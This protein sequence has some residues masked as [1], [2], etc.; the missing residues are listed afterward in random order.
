MRGLIVDLRGNGGGS[1]V[2]VADL[3]GAFVHHAT[4]SYDCTVTGQCRPNEVDNSVPM[5]RLPLVVLTDRGCVSAC[6]AFSAGVKDLGLGELA[7]TRTGGL[8]SG[9]AAAYPLDDGSLL[10]LPPPLTSSGP[11]DEMVDGIGV[12]PDYYLPMTAYDLSTGHDPD[13][14]KAL[15]LLGNSTGGSSV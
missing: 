7:G 15:Q 10:G 4:W 3:L 1:P 5:L 8:V 14:A 2:A 12:A 6:D 13:V 11:I 9:P